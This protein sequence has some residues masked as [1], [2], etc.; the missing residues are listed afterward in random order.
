MLLIHVFTCT[1]YESFLDHFIDCVNVS[2]IV[3]LNTESNNNRKYIS[4][5]GSDFVLKTVR[6]EVVGNHVH[7][8]SIDLMV[9]IKRL[10]VTSN[11]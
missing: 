10:L 6:Q 9:I 2:T 11:R 7:V 3:K 1:V 4:L 5:E 8:L